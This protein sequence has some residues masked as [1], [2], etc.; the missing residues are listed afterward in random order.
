LGNNWTAFLYG[1]GR[2]QEGKGGK[3]DKG[4]KGEEN[5]TL[6]SLSPF[7]FSPN[8]QIANRLMRLHEKTIELT[9]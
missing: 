4:D 9:Q 3:E 7:P 5:I 1:K 6:F 2:G 8:A